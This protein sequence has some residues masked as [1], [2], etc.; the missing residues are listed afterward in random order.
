MLRRRPGEIQET[1]TST[2][3]NLS[4]ATSTQM[5]LSRPGEMRNPGDPRSRPE[6]LRKCCAAG[7]EKWEI[8]E[9]HAAGP[10]ISHIPTYSTHQTTVKSQSAECAVSF[11]LAPNAQRRM[12]SLFFQAPNAQSPSPKRRMRSAECA[13]SFSKRRMRSL[14]FLQSAEYAVSFSLCPN[15]VVSF[16]FRNYHTIPNIYAHEYAIY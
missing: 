10:K 6:D 14:L 4:P 1:Y 15:G 13:V 11:S 8:Q 2:S 5:L 3:F 12:R 7:P 9:T 16:S